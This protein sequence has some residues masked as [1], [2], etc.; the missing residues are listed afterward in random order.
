MDSVVQQFVVAVALSSIVSLPIAA[1]TPVVDGQLDAAYG[2]ALVTQTTQTT[3]KNTLGT[4]GGANG[5][6]LDQGYGLISN[7][8]LYLM[9]TGNMYLQPNLGDPGTFSSPIHL[10]FDTRA[11]GQDTLRRDNDTLSTGFFP[12]LLSAS[13]LKFDHDFAPDFWL[14]CDGAGGPDFGGPYR[15]LCFFAELPT[16][17]GANVTYLGWAK[18]PGPDTLESSGGSNPYGIAVSLDN[19]NTAG[20]TQGCGASSGAGVTT[21]F[22]CAIPLAAIGDPTGPIKVCAFYGS[23][24]FSYSNQ[25][26]GPLPPGTCALGGLS[27]VDF[28]AIP[29]DQYFLVP[30]ATDAVA[31]EATREISLASRSSPGTRLVATVALPRAGPARLDVID[32]SGR[33]VLARDLDGAMGGPH[34]LELA[35]PGALAPGI[36]F[37]RLTQGATMAT[38]RA[39]ILR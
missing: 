19:S 24:S 22:E 9:L 32:S 36:Y 34:T 21:G 29:G 15:L 7:H 6:E 8:V 14:G 1:A 17:A 30:A 3:T 12:L 31:P 20:V 23:P 33:R 27:A 2:P 18:V 35:R 25:V 26:L 16:N 11:G 39:V 13:G 5:L 4:P 37:L 28:S 38:A 10:F